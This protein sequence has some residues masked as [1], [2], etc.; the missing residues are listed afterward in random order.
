MIKAQEICVI[1]SE[2]RYLLHE[3][4]RRQI[5]HYSSSTCFPTVF[6]NKQL[7]KVTVFSALHSTWRRHDT[8]SVQSLAWILSIVLKVHKCCS[9]TSSAQQTHE[10]SC[11]HQIFVP[12]Y[13]VFMWPEESSVH[14]FHKESQP[15]LGLSLF[16]ETLV[17]NPPN[18]FNIYIYIHSK[19][20]FGFL[21]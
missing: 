17:L 14:Q 8:I 6:T 5:I 12:I 7:T 15:P 9:L 10:F 19:R 1:W 2:C 18:Y 16:S 21:S 13:F 3:E 11:T 4:S 20:F